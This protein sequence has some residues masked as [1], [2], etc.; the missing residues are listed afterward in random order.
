MYTPSPS[1]AQHTFSALT[2]LKLEMLDVPRLSDLLQHSKFPSLQSLDCAFSNPSPNCSH[3]EIL[4]LISAI[5]D[6]CIAATLTRVA[7]GAVMHRPETS[8]SDSVMSDALRPLLRHQ[9][10]REFVIRSPWSWDLD[11][12]LIV[13]IARSWNEIEVLILSPNN[14]W[15][16]P[17]RITL[18]GLE[19]LA[20]HCPQ[21]A[22]F[23]AIIDT[24]A[25]LVAPD[26]FNRMPIGGKWSMSLQTL[27]VDCSPIDSPAVVAFYLSRMFPNVNV[28]EAFQSY[29]DE[30]D[31]ESDYIRWARVLD[32]LPTMVLARIEER[33]SQMARAKESAGVPIDPN[34]HHEVQVQ[35][36][37]QAQG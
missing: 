16:S 34:W 24:S 27:A 29:E 7:I 3:I 33:L 30:D 21:L 31:A 36:L 9:N 20:L 13:D 15:P 25:P 17:S 14:H 19:P 4:T 1:P 37:S 26:F 35:T 8:E 12:A 22:E 32:I 6:S 5:A 28:I 11:N 18:V 10:M 23:G 2:T